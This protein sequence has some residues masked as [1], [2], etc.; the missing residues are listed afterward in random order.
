MGGRLWEGPTMVGR[1]SDWKRELGRFLKPFLDRFGHKA[2]RQ[3]CPLYVSGLI[4]PGDRKSIAPMAKRLGLGECDQLHHFIAAGVWDAVPVEAELLVQADRLVGGSDAVL[5]IDDTALPKKGTHSVGVAPQY[6]SALGKTSN[7]Q[8]LVSLTLARDEVP[9]MMALRLFL[10]ES[11]TSD[12]ARLRRAG[13]PA[14]YRTA[15]T[16]PEM[17]LAEIDR[18]IAAGV[19]FG[20]ALADAGYGLSAP[21]RQGLTARKLAWAV[22][23][24]RHL[25]VYP[26]G[27][28]MIWPVAGRGRPRQRHVPDV[29]SMAA[30]DMLADATWQNISWR[31]GTKGE[32]KARF[33]AVRVRIADGPPQRIR[34][35]GQQ[36]LPGEEAWLIGEHRMSG[37]KKYYLANLPAKMDLRTLASIIKA[38]WICEQAH[39]QL[40][41]ELGLDHFEGRSWH[42]L[43]RH[44]LMTM[45]AYA[46]LQYRRLKTARREKKNQRAA[47]SANLARRAPGH[48]RSHRSTTAAA[49]SPLPKMDS[50]RATA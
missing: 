31:T 19:R 25:K 47:A 16:K 9:V 36:H 35:K 27:V 44:A 45:I 5:V 2:R 13:V 34:D 17:A 21:F 32:L 15:R 24:P 48:P 42:G 40:K 30:E 1:T 3:M 12:R 38:R 50:Q 41:E 29:L 26:A 39:Q 43:H 37:E 18:V 28:Q 33:A 46:F 49:M 11:W 14:E 10:P 22:G 20:C 4:G 7:C 23:I 8:T 6:A